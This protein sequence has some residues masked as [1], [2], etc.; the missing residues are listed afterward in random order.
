MIRWR[1][2]AQIYR[3]PPGD[4]TLVVVPTGSVDKLRGRPVRFF[5]RQFADSFARG[6]F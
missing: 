2:Q 6:P 4:E 1:W 3:A 5:R